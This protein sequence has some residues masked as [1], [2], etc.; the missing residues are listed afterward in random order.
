[1]T[2]LEQRLMALE[3]RSSRPRI[4]M[5]P[6]LIRAI[7]AA[8]EAEDEA[9]VAHLLEPLERSGLTYEMVNEIDRQLEAELER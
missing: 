7:N 6:E 9:Q 5:S 4:D 8:L 3:A 2:R 1:M